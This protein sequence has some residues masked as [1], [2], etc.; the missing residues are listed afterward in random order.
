LQYLYGFKQL[1][2]SPLLETTYHIHIVGNHL[3]PADSSI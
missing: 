1:F 3:G 2:L